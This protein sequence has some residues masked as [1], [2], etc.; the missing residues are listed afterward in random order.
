MSQS[1]KKAGKTLRIPGGFDRPKC[2]QIASEY[3]MTI[4]CQNTGR[5]QVKQ[6]EGNEIMQ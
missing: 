4:D 2:W 5:A 1:R 3:Y 6:P